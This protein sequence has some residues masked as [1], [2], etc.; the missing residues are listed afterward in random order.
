LVAAFTVS[1]IS[2]PAGVSVIFFDK[3]SLFSITALLMGL[4]PL[5]TAQTPA[6]NHCARIFCCCIYHRLFMKLHVGKG[7]S[8]KRQT[9]SLLHYREW[10]TKFDQR[11]SAIPRFRWRSCNQVSTMFFL[12]YGRHQMHL[13]LQAR[14]LAGDR[15]RL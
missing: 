10:F 15:R 1:L 2:K 9:D 13:L 6:L 8:M 4:L 14:G 3:W 5:P 11:F 12:N 7:L